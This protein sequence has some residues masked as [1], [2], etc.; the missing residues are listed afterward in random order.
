MGSFKVGFA[1]HTTLGLDAGLGVVLIEVYK[2]KVRIG[3]K[4]DEVDVKKQL[5]RG[6]MYTQE[7]V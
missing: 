6:S 7:A 4:N 1:V 3:N 2:Y 5:C